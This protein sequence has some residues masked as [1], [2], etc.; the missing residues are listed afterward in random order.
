MDSFDIFWEF[1]DLERQALID[2]L[3]EL[4]DALSS[5]ARASLF[6]LR[7]CDIDIF[8][9]AV[10]PEE[11]DFTWTL[12]ASCSPGQVIMLGFVS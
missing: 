10:K 12:N 8:R 6:A 7:F 5:V 11:K 3:I 4:D 9:R 2:R 1:E